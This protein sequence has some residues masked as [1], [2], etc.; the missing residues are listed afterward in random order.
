MHGDQ[1][2]GFFFPDFPLT[3]NYLICVPS[4]GFQVVRIIGDDIMNI[5]LLKICS[6]HVPFANSVFRIDIPFQ[7][8]ADF[9]Y[10]PQRTHIM[11]AISFYNMTHVVHIIIVS[12]A[13]PYLDKEIPPFVDKNLADWE[14]GIMVDWELSFILH[15]LA[16][17]FPSTR[18]YFCLFFHILYDEMNEFTGLLLTDDLLIHAI[19]FGVYKNLFTR[20]DICCMHHV[21]C[22]SF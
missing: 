6:L 14:A 17:L 12:L 13:V 7:Q 4:L 22:L 15:F 16:Y 20:P 21:I 19:S 2:R 5:L 9:S 8:F 1:G 18:K 3:Q 10:Y 11:I